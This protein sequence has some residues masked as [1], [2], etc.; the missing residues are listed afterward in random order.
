MKPN[1]GDVL[2]ATKPDHETAA[3]RTMNEETRQSSMLLRAARAG[4][5]EALGS[6]LDRYGEWLL[7]LIRARL[8][9][10]LRREVGSR[11]VLQETLLA[12]FRDLEQF[13]GSGTATFRGWMAGIAVNKIR[14]QARY[15]RRLARDRRLRNSWY[16][17]FDP[18]ARQLHT[19]VSRIQLGRRAQRLERVLDGL[20]A[21]HREVILLRQYE[22]LSFREIGERMG[23]SEDAARML[24]ARAMAKVTLQMQ[25]EERN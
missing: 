24:L 7:A 1:A 20:S 21:P 5:R 12:A 15:F 17:G 10:G 16:S 18:A 14:Y 22:E 19:Q 8:G 2:V 9:P 25:E 23:R 6:L 11:D 3:R 13:Q 4:S